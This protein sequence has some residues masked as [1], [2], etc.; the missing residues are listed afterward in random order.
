MYVLVYVAYG[1]LFYDQAHSGLA[2]LNKLVKGLRVDMS[3]LQTEKK[4][5]CLIL[6]MQGVV[7]HSC[8]CVLG[9]QFSL[10]GCCCSAVCGG[11]VTGNGSDLAC[12]PFS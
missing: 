5:V 6:V 9:L 12:N 4:G 3:T 10:C 2:E 7:F 1:P 11:P 8:Q